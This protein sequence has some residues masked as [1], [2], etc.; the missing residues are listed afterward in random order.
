MSKYELGNNT[1]AI[2]GLKNGK[3]RVIEN[4]SDFIIGEHAY[5]VM[6]NSCSYFGSS[7][8]GRVD[9]SRKLLGCNYKVP[10]I[11]EESNELIFFPTAS[12]ITKCCGW[13]SLN[14]ISSIE[15]KNNKANV[16]LING[17][18]ITI[19]TSKNSLDNQILRATRLKY[20][21][22]SRKAEKKGKIAK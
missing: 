10:I 1:L 21:I 19:D 8:Q 4:D 2:I 17:K 12:P 11:V 18:H 3:T 9:G 7:Y 13:F 20:L 15:K 6:E 5:E 16:T 14:S 22:N